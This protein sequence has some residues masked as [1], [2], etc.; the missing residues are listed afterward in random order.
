MEKSSLTLEAFRRQFIE[1]L[2]AKGIKPPQPN[3]EKEK[4]MYKQWLEGQ[5]KLEQASNELTQ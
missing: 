3:S 5:Q 2:V 1:Q 4:K